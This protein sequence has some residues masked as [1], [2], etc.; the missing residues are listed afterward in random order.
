[1][2]SNRIKNREDLKELIKY[3]NQVRQICE[4]CYY[5]DKDEDDDEIKLPIKF[6]ICR[7]KS[8]KFFLKQSIYYRKR[9]FDR[10]GYWRKK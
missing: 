3:S 7:H 8:F 9:N 4:T 2:N 10:C 5:W 6:G 1:M